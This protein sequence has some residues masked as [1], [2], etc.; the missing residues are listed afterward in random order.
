MVLFVAKKSYFLLKMNVK[1]LKIEN[2]GLAVWQ[3]LLIIVFCGIV[4]A[5]IL[6]Q[7]IKRQ[8]SSVIAKVV[9]ENLILFTQK[10]NLTPLECNS[11]DNNDDGWIQCRAED[12]NQNTIYLQCA[13]D[14]RRS[15]CQ[16]VQES[17]K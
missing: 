15:N 2:A 6:P 10:N 11:Q 14:Q 7:F 5:L 12:T 8:N 13:Y 1:D 16:K 3:L 4:S 17:R 9:K